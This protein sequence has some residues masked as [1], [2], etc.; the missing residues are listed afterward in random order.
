MIGTDDVQ[1]AASG[2]TTANF[3]DPNVANATTVTVTNLTLTGNAASNYTLLNPTETASAT[4]SPRG[5]DGSISA[6]SKTYDGTTT[7]DGYWTLGE[8]TADPANSG[9]TGVI[10]TD[11][12]QLAA[13]GTT[14]ANFNDP[15][16]ANA[17]TVTVTN[18]TLTGNAASNYTLLNPTETANATITPRG[19]DGSIS[20][21]SKTYDGTTTADGYWTLGELTADPANSGNTGVI[22]TDDVQLAASGTTTANFNDPNVANATTVTVTN[23]TLSGNAA[24]NYTLLN[25]TETA[26]PPSLRVGSMAASVPPAR[27]TTAPPRPMATG[28]W[29]S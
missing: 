27:R 13:S 7:A 1:L 9:N 29:V 17:T 18:L 28:R 22:G 20:A 25:P 11:D 2:T 5:V 16:V 12:V 10:G 15:N 3:N 4:I 14:T 6:S 19:V 23:L 8:L 26:R 24:S 21:S